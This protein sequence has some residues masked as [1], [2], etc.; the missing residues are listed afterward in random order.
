MPISYTELPRDI[1]EISGADQRT[2]LQ[3][4]ISQD[5]AN[6][7]P[8]QSAYGALLTPQGKYLHDFIMVQRGD[9]LLLDC[10]QGRSADLVSRLSRFRLRAD[11]ALDLRADFKVFVAFGDRTARALGLEGSPGTTL[12]D[13]HVSLMV[14]PRTDRLGC[15]LIGPAEDIAAILGQS[16]LRAA[17][18]RDYDQLRISLGVPD[19]SRDMEIEKSIL[20]ESNIDDLHGIAWEKGCYMGQ[21]LTARTKYRGLVKRRLVAFEAVDNDA[22]PGDPLVADG[23]VVGE[24]RSASGNLLLASV[25]TDAMDNAEYP[26]SLENG[27]LKRILQPAE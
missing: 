18:F 4:L 27:A 17:E 6:V 5:V 14:D 22:A 11:V 1:V 25:R 12:Q 13:G 21:E 10:E 8:Q 16:D 20:L 26:V 15:R 2:F 23:K 7:T 24:V 9:K 3:G 19:G